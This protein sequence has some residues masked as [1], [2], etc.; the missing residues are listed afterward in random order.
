M[1]FWL[2]SQEQTF[3]CVLVL[4]F[5]SDALSIC[6]SHLRDQIPQQDGVVFGPGACDYDVVGGGEAG[7]KRV[8]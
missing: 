8:F 4:F 2:R 6:F 7:E 5:S 3:F 1:V